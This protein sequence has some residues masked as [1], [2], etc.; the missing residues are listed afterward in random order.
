MG[1]HGKVWIVGA[2]PGAPGLITVR[3]QQL[4]RKADVVLFDR[5]VNPAI[6]SWARDGAELLDVGKMPGGRRTEQETICGLLSQKAKKGLRVVR[7]KGG[8]PFVFGRGGEEAIWLAQRNIPFEV[9]PGVTSGIAVPAAAGIPVTHRGVSTEVAF[10]IGARAKGSVEGKTLV[11]FMSV[12]GLGTFLRESMECGFTKSSPMAL[13]EQGTLP[14]QKTLFST[15][16]RMLEGA[17]KMKI[18]PPAIVVVG[19]VVALRHQIGRQSKGKL[20]GQRVIL[21]VSSALAKG[22]REVFEEEGAEVWEMPMTQIQE[23]PMKHGWERDLKNATWIAF[24][25]GAGVRALLHAVGDIR[26]LAGKRVAVVGPSTAQIC[27]QHGLG[28]DFIGPGPGATALA[29]HWPGKKDQ[30]VLH[31]AGSAEEGVLL[32]ALQKRG[33]SVKR[34]LMYRNIAPPR[35]PKVILQ[36]LQTDGAEWVVFASGTSAERFHRLMGKS[37]AT[38]TKTA[39]IGEST[40]QTARQAGWKVVA[41]SKDVSARAVLSA[42]LKAR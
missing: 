40:A 5:L 39:V 22:W 23:I 33:F 17:K 28:V 42:M 18:R 30:G 3:G 14:T 21:T 36:K 15:V 19:D 13:I 27:R 11:G 25:S 6:L 31:C 12:E 29:K 32:D 1:K 16:G 38:G 35:P 7:L 37:W 24:T 34:I 20:S 8:D 4:L 41:K 9:V 10:Q 26:K 2:G